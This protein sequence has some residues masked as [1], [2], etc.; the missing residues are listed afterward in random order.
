MIIETHDRFKSGTSQALF[1]VMQNK[2][3][4]LNVK[5][6]DLVFESKTYRSK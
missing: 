3:F 6:E 5:G 1:K 2:E 4:I